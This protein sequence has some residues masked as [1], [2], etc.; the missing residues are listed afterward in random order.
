[1]I[2][3]FFHLPPVSLTPV[4]HLELQI[5]LRMFQNIETALM[6]CSGAWGKLIHEKKTEGD[7]V[8][9]KGIVQCPAS[10]EWTESELALA[11]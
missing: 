3:D 2:E 4:V 7:T 8:P 11:R 5:S 9:L 6:V 1:M 10:L